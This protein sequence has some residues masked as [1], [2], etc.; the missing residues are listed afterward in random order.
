MLKTKRTYPLIF[1]MA[2]F[3]MC[4]SSLPCMPAHAQESAPQIPQNNFTGAPSFRIIRVIDGNTFVILFHGQETPAR[5]IGVDALATDV[6][7]NEAQDY[8]GL[9][10]LFLQKLLTD[11]SVYLMRD[12]TAQEYD[13]NGRMLIYA[14]RVPDGLFVNLE[15]VRQGYARVS[16]EYPS[17]YLD[18]FKYYEQKAR[19]SGKRLLPAQGALTR[20]PEK[21][22]SQKLSVA[23]ED[24]KGD[25]LR[26]LSDQKKEIGLEEET[27]APELSGAIS[28]IGN[29]FQIINNNDYP[30]VN[31]RIELNG[32]I[33]H[34][35]YIH[36]LKS[37]APGKI[38]DIPAEYF[39]DRDGKPFD[40]STTK[41]KNMF[42]SCD[43]PDGI[44]YFISQW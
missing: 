3:L 28:Y 42:I 13:D 33:A 30:W 4:F 6:P 22:T 35:G 12:T 20:Q 24:I 14:Y 5:L 2:F 21:R 39:T 15:M 43:T 27:E 7:A 1:L 38:I 29:S 10:T 23:D 19:I 16:V 8:I 32:G 18:L 31:V 44:G 37:L 36:P 25:A 11:E 26:Q 9:A 34:G 41:P 17:V 40:P